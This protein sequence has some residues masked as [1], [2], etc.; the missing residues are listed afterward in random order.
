MNGNKLSEIDNKTFATQNK[1]E[2]LSIRDNNLRTLYSDSFVGL[3]KLERLYLSNNQLRKLPVGLFRNTPKLRFLDL[4]SN[5]I[6]SLEKSAFE[7]P[8]AVLQMLI[9]SYNQ[10]RSFPPG[11]FQ[12]FPSLVALSLTG[13]P[14]QHMPN[15]TR[16]PHLNFLSI[17]ST[18]ISSIY[19]CDFVGLTSLTDFH[20][21]GK[22]PLNCNCNLRWLR[23]WWQKTASNVTRKIT[24]LFPWK[25]ERPV[26]VKGKFFDKMKPSEFEC[27]SGARPSWCHL[28]GKALTLALHI[29]RVDAMADSFTVHWLLNGSIDYSRIVVSYRDDEGLGGSYVAGESEQSLTVEHLTPGATYRICVEAQSLFHAMISR[30]CVAR[31]MKR[32]NNGKGWLAGAVV[33]P[34]L[35]VFGT[36]AVLLWLYGRRFGFKG[37]AETTPSFGDENHSVHGID[38]LTYDVTSPS[39]E[40]VYET[41]DMVVSE[42]NSKV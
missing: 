24:S 2:D 25:C 7:G 31:Q 39:E 33:I 5:L 6:A 14:M 10:I 20:W 22:S 21:G 8:Q 4:R 40:H 3:N 30:D 9:F 26:E 36:A 18:G 19:Q 1:L 13:L 37:R 12:Q 23:Q 27:R 15:I 17:V 35:L 34:L 16:L 29:A 38:N 41:P 11:F 28:K 42:D 32:A